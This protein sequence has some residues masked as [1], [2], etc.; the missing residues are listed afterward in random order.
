MRISSRMPRSSALLACVVVLVV[1]APF[2]FAQAQ[3]PG[4]TLARI[5]QTPTLTFGFRTDARPFS[6][7]DIAG[8]QSGYSITLCNEIG[9]AVKRELDMP[10]LVVQWAP[11]T[12]EN[13]AQSLQD[14]TVDLLCGADTITSERA[15]YVSFS[16]PIFPGG[17]GA[18]VRADAPAALKDALANR[19]PLTGGAHVGAMPPGPRDVSV[20][21]GTL[22]QSWLAERMRALHVNARI[23]P[24]PDYDDGVKRLLDRQTAVFFGDRAILLAAASHAI[25]RDVVVINRQFTDEPVGLVLRR[26]DDNFRLLVD[27]TLAS[28]FRSDE[29]SVM[30]MQS[31]GVLDDTTKAYLVQHSVSE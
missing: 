18:M 8:I 24:V 19:L 30:Y 16:I 15:E 6:Y 21:A 2:V 13:R 3:P 31:F 28:V 14:G 25:T 17:T 10:D 27:R 9:A 1:I 4:D 23:T 26:G 5:R 11:V 20:V 22:T 7:R 29:F 12:I